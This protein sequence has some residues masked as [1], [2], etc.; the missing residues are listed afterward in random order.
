MWKKGKTWALVLP[1]ALSTILLTGAV[2]LIA[3]FNWYIGVALAVPTVVLIVYTGVRIAQLDHDVRRYVQRTVTELTEDDPSA[4]N[5]FPLA[6]LAVS[7][8]GE[9]LYANRLFNEQVSNDPALIGNPFSALFEGVTPEVW[10][11]TDLL[12]MQYKDKQYTVFIRKN[13]TGEPA[14]ILFFVDDTDFK[15]IAAEYRASRPAALMLYIDNMDEVLQNARESERARLSGLVENLLEDWLADAGGILRKF[16]D[17]RFL[18]VMEHR[19]LQRAIDVKFSIMEQVRAIHTG[20]NMKLTMSIGVGVGDTF[21]DCELSARQALEMA[22]G[23]GGDQVAIKVE[24]EYHFFGGVSTGVEKHNKVRSRVMAAAIRDAIGEC[25]R[26][27]VMG[28]RFSDLDSLGSA[29]GMAALARGLGKPAYVVV[30]SNKS[31]A[32]ELID[33]YGQTHPDAFIEP[34]KALSLVTPNTLLIITDT[35]RCEMLESAE[36]YQ[37]AKAVVV[38][39]HHRKMVGHINRALLVYHEP[40]ASSAAEMVTEMIPYLNNKSISRAEAEAL[41]AGIMLDTRSFVMKVGVRTFEAAA[42]L[43]RFGADTIKVKR[44]FAGSMEMYQTKAEIVSKAEMYR[45]TAIS[46]YGAGGTELRVASAQAADELLSVQDVRAS[47]TMF[48]ENDEVYVSARS[49]G[50]FNVQLV[51]EELGGGGHYMMAGA[52]LKDTTLEHA[53]N[54]VMEAIDH[55][56]DINT[57]E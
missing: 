44:L 38:I 5:R 8:D 20:D 25:E 12:D 49:L 57:E 51:M 15:E 4:I 53:K 7:A 41:L 36:L 40:Y 50:D 45:Q 33:S 34:E 21:R 9:V 28:H 37:R 2:A 35:F 30:D 19:H 18:A 39:D 14:Y 52:Q 16:D 17:D 24:N 27:L 54:R 29:I 13:T 6:A 10:Q 43:R 32:K 1:M 23:R 56:L 26:V 22:L 31:V 46:C 55:Y 47:F 3:W 11:N 42:A 48:A